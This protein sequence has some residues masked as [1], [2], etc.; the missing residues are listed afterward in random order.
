MSSH[1]GKAEWVMVADTERHTL[2]FL[3]NDAANGKSVVE[4][5]ASQNCTDAIFAEIGYGA[6]GHL[7]S[8]NIH[9]WIAP[10][11]V[12]GRQTL[13]MFEHLRLKPATSASEE[14]RNHVC[15]CAKKTGSETASCCHS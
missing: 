15:C 4:L 3:E 5:I 12:T 2:V 6:L 11:A 9:G 7:Q 10:P 14:N 13:E 8:A 1:F